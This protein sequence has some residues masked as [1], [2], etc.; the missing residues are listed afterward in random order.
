[1]ARK[2]FISYASADSDFAA[3]VARELELNGF[4]SWLDH[5]S[6]LAATDWLFEIDRS[7]DQSLALLAIISP[8]SAQS[9]FVTYEWA[10]ALGRGRCVIP[11]LLKKADYH[12]RL[13][14]IQYLDFSIPALRP[15]DELFARL[16]ALASHEASVPKELALGLVSL[17]EASS[18]PMLITDISRKVIRCNQSLA[19][20]VGAKPKDIEGKPFKVLLKLLADRVPGTRRAEF[21]VR[22]L[23]LQKSYDD[24]RLPNAVREEYFDNTGF[25]DSNPWNS[26]ML[27]RIHADRLS[28]NGDDVGYFAVYDVKRVPD[29]P[30]RS[31]NETWLFEQAQNSRYEGLDSARCR[32]QILG[33]L[34]AILRDAEDVYGRAWCDEVRTSW[35]IVLE[36]V[37]ATF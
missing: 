20:V 29:I 3:L 15:W 4:K 12:P 34:E 19:N 26:R 18:Q 7:I 1:M 36:D 30:K 28:L 22:Q 33:H 31:L 25:P 13:R 16:K 23:D 9:H 35:A 2:V 24:N 37:L 6:I 8:D 5:E 32:V 11:L 21:I 14:V 10:Y 27:I 17:L